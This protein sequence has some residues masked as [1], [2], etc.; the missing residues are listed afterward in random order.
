MPQQSWKEKLEEVCHAGHVPSWVGHLL[1]SQQRGQGFHLP[2]PCFKH[3]AAHPRR[4]QGGSRLLAFSSLLTADISTPCLCPHLFLKP[5]PF[6]Q[7]PPTSVWREGNAERLSC[8]RLG[9]LLPP[10]MTRNQST[11]SASSRLCPETQ[12]TIPK[13]SQVC[14]GGR[15]VT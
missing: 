1:M 2:A 11:S 14:K 12:T 9:P 5:V 13:P 6:P 8:C 15:N 3:E 4:V 7:L 10:G